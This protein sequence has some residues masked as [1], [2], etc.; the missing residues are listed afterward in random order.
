MGL[1]ELLELLQ[2][3]T[4]K[5]LFN[6]KRLSTESHWSRPRIF[7]M[8]EY[9]PRD[10]LGE[11]DILRHF[12]AVSMRAQEKKFNVGMK[13]EAHDLDAWTSTLQLLR[14]ADGRIATSIVWLLNLDCIESRVTPTIET[15]RE[16]LD[17]KNLGCN[18]CPHRK[19]N[20][21]TATAA[22]R[23]LFESAVNPKESLSSISNS[24][25]D[26]STCVNIWLR[27]ATDTIVY[28]YA[29][30]RWVKVGKSCLAVEVVRDLGHAK[31]ARDPTWICHLEAEDDVCSDKL[32]ARAT[33]S[34]N[35][36]TPL[37][38]EE[39]ELDLF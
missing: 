28:S 1:P 38:M 34:G 2:L 32:A 22:V 14:T 25:S 39:L 16:E 21:I 4:L 36:H 18:L 20:D 11:L 13:L 35:L 24:C 19:I 31:S 3:D 27:K 33:C 26:C 10:P 7:E 37:G 9:S 17:G 5:D 6:M 8:D 12:A 29:S 15:I 23:E 30:I